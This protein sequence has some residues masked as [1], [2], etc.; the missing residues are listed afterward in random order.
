MARSAT[1]GPMRTDELDLS[2]DPE[3]EFV[4]SID[5]A[6]VGR[7]MEEPSKSR[8]L[9]VATDHAARAPVINS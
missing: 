3:R 9:D 8:W 4:V 5:A 7:R 2:N 1:R 6:H